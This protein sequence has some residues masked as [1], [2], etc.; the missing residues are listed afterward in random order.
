MLEETLPQKIRSHRD[1]VVWNKAMDMAD[2]VLRLAGMFPKHQLYILTPQLMRAAA[3]VP[4][5]IAEGNGRGTRRD[6][7]N[8]ISIARGSLAEAETFLSL[9][10]RRCYIEQAETATAYQLMDEVGRMLT[11]LHGRLRE[12]PTSAP[13]P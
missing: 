10:V 2:E 9:A 12:P 11:A 1:L 6:Y 5:N 3:S 13:N 7:A 4:A 8:F